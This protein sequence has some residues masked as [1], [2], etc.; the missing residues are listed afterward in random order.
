MP[1][2]PPKTNMPTTMLS[3]LSSEP[4]LEAARRKAATPDEYV[5]SKR[6]EIGAE[7]EYLRNNLQRYAQLTSLTNAPKLE[8]NLGTLSQSTDQGESS[9]TRLACGPVPHPGLERGMDEKPTPLSGK[10]TAKTKVS[11]VV[12]R[13]PAASSLSDSNFIVNVD[14]TKLTPHTSKW[15]RRR[16]VR[17]KRRLQGLEIQQATSKCIS[18]NLEQRLKVVQD[19]A[20]QRPS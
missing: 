10:R 12:V 11:D 1:L 14:K 13:S 4:K 7:F 17:I 20:R 8:G 9:G 15:D 19:H 3:S 2:P 6:G 16:V 18:E 5:L